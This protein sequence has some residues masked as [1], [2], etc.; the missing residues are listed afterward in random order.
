MSPRT[1]RY[2][3]LDAQQM[4]TEDGWKL[5]NA[6]MCYRSWVNGAKRFSHTNS[7]A[8]RSKLI[9]AEWSAMTKNEKRQWKNRYMP[10]VRKNL[11]AARSK[12]LTASDAQPSPLHESLAASYYR[13]PRQRGI[14]KKGRAYP[15][16]VEVPR[17]QTR[18]PPA[19]DPHFSADTG[20]TPSNYAESPAATS[21]TDVSVNDEHWFPSMSPDV[22]T[23][24]GTMAAESLDEKDLFREWCTFSD[25]ED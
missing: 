6:Y 7:Q 3:K 13:A 8:E 23:S 24:S 20:S 21:S 2:A 25:S 18:S 19:P 11:L 17:S 9:G 15:P 4:E 10:A 16:S 5:P 12:A 1:P 22:G 14:R